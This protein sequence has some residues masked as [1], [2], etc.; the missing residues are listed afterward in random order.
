MIPPEVTKKSNAIQYMFY[1]AFLENYNEIFRWYAL[2]D[3]LKSFINFLLVKINI[4]N[5]KLAE[6]SNVNIEKGKEKVGKPSC[7]FIFS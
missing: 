3:N 7:L 4:S 2:M 6:S 1:S 5:Q